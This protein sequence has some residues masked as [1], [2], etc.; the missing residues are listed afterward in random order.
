MKTT[1]NKEKNLEDALINLYFFIKTQDNVK[2]KNKKFKKI[3]IIKY[4]E[5]NTQ[6]IRL[7]QKSRNYR[8]LM[9]L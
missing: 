3:K 1:T 9:L 5:K 4:R 6:K 7:I 8:D 2:I